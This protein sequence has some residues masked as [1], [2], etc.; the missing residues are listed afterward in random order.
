[1]AV[2]AIAEEDPRRADNAAL[3][4]DLDEAM[5]AL[6][7]REA[8]HFMSPDQ[9]V[10]GGCILL[11]ARHGDDAA[12]CAALV[13]R[14]NGAGELK[15]MWTIPAARGRGIGR[16]LCRAVAVRAANEGMAVL[17]LE[18]GVRQPEA[19]GLFLSEGFVERGPF[20]PYADDPDLI[21]MEKPVTI[22]AGETA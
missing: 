17:R 20:P 8:C 14:G 18:T 4:A 6:Y 2:L 16:A 5:L 1:V 11:V 13:P 15:R 3:I 10:A 19:R 7:R 12:G 9:L 21:F 22:G